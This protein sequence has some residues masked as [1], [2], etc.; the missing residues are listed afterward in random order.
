MA[1]I[2]FDDFCLLANQV[3][4]AYVMTPKRW[5]TVGKNYKQHST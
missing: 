2:D 1:V 5:K 3:T 4:S